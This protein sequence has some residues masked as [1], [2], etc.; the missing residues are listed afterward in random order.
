VALWKAEGDPASVLPLLRKSLSEPM[1]AAIIQ[2]FGV[3]ED[4]RISQK[5]WA[6][7]CLGEMGQQ[8]DKAADEIAQA[9]NDNDDSELQL[10]GIRALVKIG[11]TSP[12]ILKSLEKLTRNPLPVVADEAK[13]ALE[14]LNAIK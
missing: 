14:K 7:T 11:R 4:T 13:L 5:S 10:E 8:A 3:S 12:A 1:A 9:L 6:V 2:P